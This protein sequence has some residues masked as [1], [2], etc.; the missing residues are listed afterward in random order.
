MFLFA[1]PL[2]ISN[3][4]MWSTKATLFYFICIY[5]YHEKT[6]HISLLKSNRKKYLRAVLLADLRAIVLRII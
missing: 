6:I 4:H 5:L 1:P 3:C 2:H